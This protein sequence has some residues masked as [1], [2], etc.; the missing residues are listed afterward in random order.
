VHAGAR[1]ALYRESGFVFGTTRKFVAMQRIRQL[2]GA[3]L[4][5]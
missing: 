3:Q 1:A 4:N 5:P 2:L